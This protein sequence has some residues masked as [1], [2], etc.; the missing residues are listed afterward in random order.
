M[1]SV[2]LRPDPHLEP[3]TLEQR[4][5]ALEQRFAGAVLAATNAA[6]A[7]AGATHVAPGSMRDKKM[8]IVPY[9]QTP[10]SKDD[11]A[12]DAWRELREIE[13]KLAY[14]AA[15]SDIE[16]ECV[17]VDG[18][19]DPTEWDTRAIASPIA[20]SHQHQKEYLPIIQNAVRY[21][22]LR[23]L[24]RRRADAPEIIQILELP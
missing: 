17:P 24:I 11:A 3:L 16:C 9:D 8:V 2:A 18:E 23:G 10:S 14:S 5:E 19:A 4:V 15:R 7:A 21:L 12:C 1:N 13:Q 20:R 22:E 6:L